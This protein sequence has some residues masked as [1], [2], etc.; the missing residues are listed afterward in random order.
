[1]CL[2]AGGNNGGGDSMRD[3]RR[4]GWVPAFA[5]NNGVVRWNNGW[6]GGTGGSRTAPMVVD[7][8]GSM[9]PRMRRG[10]TGGG[11][12]RFADRPYGR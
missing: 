6:V 5:R 2:R 7:L 11:G 10:F 3:K 12:G 8:T 1:M 9:G 4:E